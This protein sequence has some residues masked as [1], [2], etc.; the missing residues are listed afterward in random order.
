MVK[1]RNDLKNIVDLS[2]PTCE[3]GVAEG[4][5]SRDILSWGSQKHYMVDLWQHQPDVTGDGNSTQEWHNINLENV[6]IITSPYE[7]KAVILQGY[8]SKMAERI[9]DESL[10]FLYLDAAHDYQNVLN[11]L[12]AY[13][14]KVAHGGIVAGHDFDN[15]AYGVKDAVIVFCKQHGYR[16]TLIPDISSNHSGFWFRKTH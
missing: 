14:P 7:E 3:V 12:E 9:P 4:L 2:L 5:F 15:P 10:G 11:D 16:W 8:S 13:V 6:K 1:F